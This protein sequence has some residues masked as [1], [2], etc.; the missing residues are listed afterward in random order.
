[1]IAQD[2]LDMIK[3]PSFN[4]DEALTSTKFAT[5]TDEMKKFVQE[6]DKSRKKMKESE[7]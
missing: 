1:M 5:L 2:I 3:S 4:L 7:K 6:L